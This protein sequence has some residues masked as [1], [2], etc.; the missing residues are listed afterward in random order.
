MYDLTTTRLIFPDSLPYQ[1]SCLVHQKSDL[2]SLQGDITIPSWDLDLIHR[3]TE[4]DDLILSN[5]ADDNAL[6]TIAGNIQ[7]VYRRP[8]SDKSLPS[9]PDEMFICRYCIAFNPRIESSSEG[10]VRIMPFVGKDDRWEDCV[11][12]NGE[13]ATNIIHRQDD[14]EPSKERLPSI[15]SP[16]TTSSKKRLRFYSEDSVDGSTDEPHPTGGSAV[17]GEGT[18]D[19][20]NT[21]VGRKHQ[22]SVPRYDANHKPTTV[23]RNPKPVWKPGQVSRDTVQSYMTKAAGILIPYLEQEGLTHTVPYSPLAWE[24]MEALTKE[25]NSGKLPT[26]ST[27]CTASALAEKRTDMLREVDTGALMQ[28]LHE[29]SYDAEDALR[30][31]E[32]TPKKFVTAM[33][34]EQ[35]NVV[36][37]AFRRYAGSFRMSY[38][39]LA[40]AKSFQEVIDYLYRF[41]IP[42]QFRLFQETKRE[43][44]VQML[45][46]I[47]SR[48]NVHACINADKVPAERPKVIEWYVPGFVVVTFVVSPPT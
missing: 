1:A 9:L 15:S 33:T 40:P 18:V 4:D 19:A 13:R 8:E 29:H 31:I 27:I 25:M 6:T 2:Q 46:S 16:S 5:Q 36:D 32:A 10:F 7:V 47:E 30:A 12:S 43:L 44:A 48:R 45:E 23:S 22:V 38:K 34:G 26:L 3:I 28:L 37:F 14:H 41:K 42:D 20:R 17:I 35:K 21:R 24:E 11:T 39:A